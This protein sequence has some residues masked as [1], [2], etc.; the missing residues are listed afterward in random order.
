MKIDRR[1]IW[2]YELFEA[3]LEDS[4][5]RRW[6]LARVLARGGLADIKAIGLETIREALPSLVLPRKIRDFW[7]SYFALLDRAASPS[8]S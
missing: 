3:D 5:V 1:F 2:D 8:K 4:Q 6:Y 7:N